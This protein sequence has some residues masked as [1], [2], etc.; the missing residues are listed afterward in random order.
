M[1]N[2]LRLYQ[3]PAAIEAILDESQDG[4]LS[5][6]QERQLDAILGEDLPARVKSVIRVIRDGELMDKACGEEKDRI[7]R[8]RQAAQNRVKSWK[9]YL[10][11]CMAHAEVKRVAT[12]LGVVS[13][14]PNSR[15]TIRW[16]FAGPPPPEFTRTKIVVEIDGDRVYQAYRAGN[17]P[18]GFEV[19]LDESL[20]IR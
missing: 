8:I 16:A 13:R 10:L 2:N 9:E 5:S 4:E 12:E 11:R 7:T 15:P 20:R 3:I 18:D 17:L 1:G 19:I 6:D 14:C